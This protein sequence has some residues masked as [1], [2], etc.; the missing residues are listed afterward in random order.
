MKRFPTLDES[1]SGHTDETAY[2]SGDVDALDTID[3][4]ALREHARGYAA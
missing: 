1:E 3:A 2:L 4:D